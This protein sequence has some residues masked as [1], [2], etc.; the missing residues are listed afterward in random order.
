MSRSISSCI[1]S[2]AAVATCMAFAPAAAAQKPAQPKPAA[3]P[4]K[5]APAATPATTPA[6]AA[7][8]AEP[9]TPPPAVDETDRADDPRAIYLS[10][11]LGF[12]RADIG[13]LSDTFGFDKTGA[14][15]LVAGIGVGYRYKA[16]RLGGRFRDAS[17]TEYSLWS[18]MGE[19]GFG[20][21]FRPLTPVIFVHAGYI[22]DEGVERSVIASS[23]PKQNVLTPNIELDGLVIGAEAYLAYSVTRFLKI[24]PFLGADFTFLHRAQPGPP[25]SLQPT[26]EKV[27]NNALFNDSG[28]GVGYMLNLGVRLTGDVAF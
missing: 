25:Q 15:G 12:T 1:V 19:V 9:T 2:L 22:F 3:A 26:D 16:L 28:S 6:P 21:P 18:L 14:N 7:A 10:G 13:G 20:L 11:E 23:L 24:G 17:T 8:P 27:P 4:A 5:A